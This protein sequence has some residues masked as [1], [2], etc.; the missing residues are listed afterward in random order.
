MRPT[1]FTIGSLPIRSYEVL[2][3]IGFL[4]ALYIAI[5]R[6]K[7]KNIPFRFILDL[8]LYVLISGFVGARIFY[9]LQHIRSYDSLSNAFSSI[10]EGGLTYYGG[11]VLASFVGFIYL[12]SIRLPIAEVMDIIAPSL[13]LGEGIARIGCFLAGCCFGKPTN[14]P[15]GVT[16]PENTLTGIITDS[17]KVHPTQ[18]Y[19]SVILFCIFII[20]IIFQ[21]Y[22]KFSG[23][24]FLSYMIMYSIYRFSIDFLRYYNPEEH[25][26][27]FAYSQVTSLV[28]GLTAIIIMIRRI[29]FFRN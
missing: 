15:C 10:W 5:Q 1:L 22:A 17:Q 7:K 3:A 21:K 8:G 28:L 4:I 12:R 26:G 27:I 2:V 24:L 14:L 19:S 11:F 13:A 20:L 6:A 18:L 23:Q 25:L 9:I 29:W 16:F